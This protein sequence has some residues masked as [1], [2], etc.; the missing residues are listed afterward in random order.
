VT[1]LLWPCAVLHV[2]AAGCVR[3]DE[4]E[5]R[6]SPMSMKIAETRIGCG[7]TVLPLRDG[8]Y[9]PW[10]LPGLGRLASPATCLPQA[11]AWEPALRLCGWR[12]P[13]GPLTSASEQNALMSIEAKAP[14]NCTHAVRLPAE[15]TNE[16][17]T[18]H[19]CRSRDATAPRD[20]TRYCQGVFDICGSDPVVSTLSQKFAAI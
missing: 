4:Y 3:R 2:T 11:A 16:R 14:P 1:T 19:C 17:P 8:R 7:R 10:P 5:Q 6:V 20:E 13:R 18:N 15:Q 12:T 9:R